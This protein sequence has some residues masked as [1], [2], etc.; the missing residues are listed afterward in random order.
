MTVQGLREGL[1]VGRGLAGHSARQ[2]TPPPTSAANHSGSHYARQMTPPPVPPANRAPT[3]PPSGHPPHWT[4]LSD[5]RIVKVRGRNERFLTFRAAGRQCRQLR[6]TTARKST[7]GEAARKESH[8]AVEAKR[9]R[10][11]LCRASAISLTFPICN[12]TGTSRFGSALY[13]HLFAC[14]ECSPLALTHAT[15]HRGT[16][17]RRA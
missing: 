13:R 16:E 5:C 8:R 3:P 2:M 9:A 7:A 6:Q 17:P 15:D 4:E 10:L 1:R 14:P 12:V 11:A